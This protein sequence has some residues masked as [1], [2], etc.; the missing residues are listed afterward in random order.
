MAP[1]SGLTSRPSSPGPYVPQ[2]ESLILPDGAL[3][4]E[5]AGLLEDLV[6]HHPHHRRIE[7][8]NEREDDFDADADYHRGREHHKQLPWWKRPSPWWVLCIMPFT[9]IAM[10]ATIAP[11]IEIYTMLACR[12]HKPDIFRQTLP[13]LGGMF[14]FPGTSP[15]LPPMI[16]ANTTFNDNFGI[17]S[18]DM[19]NG[20]STPDKPNNACASDPTVQAAVAK[21]NA[22]ITT[23]MGILSCLT[24]GWWGSFSDRHGRKRLLG[25][26][27]IGVLA[28]DLN[29]IFVSR[30]FQRL[31]GGYWFMILG[32]LIDGSVGSVTAS[33]AAI[34]AYVADTTPEVK[35]SRV[36]SLSLGLLFAGM[37]LGPT[38]GG[39]LIRFSG[40]VLSVF[41]AAAVVHF[42]YA[43]LVWLALPES[44]LKSQMQTSQLKYDKELRK[45][46]LERASNPAVGLLFRSKRLFAFLSPLTTF[47]PEMDPVRPGE[48][49]LKRKRKD[50][51]L[52][53]I[54]AAYGLAFSIMFAASAFGWNS[55][56]MGYWLSMVGA[57]RA[58][59]LAIVLPCIISFFKLRGKTSTLEAS[60]N[61]SE[62]EPFLSDTIQKPKREHSAAFDLGLAHVSLVVEV[63]S[64]TFMAIAP[65]A[66]F[67]TLFSMAAAMGSGLNPALQSVALAMYRRRGGTESGRLFGALSVVQALSSQILGPALYGLVYVKTVATFPRAI[68]IVSMVTIMLSYAFLL[69]VRLPKDS[70]ELNA[71]DA[72]L[73]VGE[74]G[75]LMGE[76]THAPRR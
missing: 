22:V 66:F 69:F 38:L 61:T 57:T 67:F 62:G 24:T 19:K 5:A 23:S 33:V 35:R 47:L 52:T 39:L 6:H 4:E 10:S 30:N 9:A 15:I 18:S 48:N 74:E 56:T 36:F 3:G 76:E 70:S 44:L 13:S 73:A 37:A 41:Y 54:A 14:D 63:I 49:P 32:P 29:F 40:S 58:L 27:V 53:L 45:S 31:P 26:S 50:W 65:T 16:P 42:I 1:R 17:S 60:R 28:T 46:A 68:F 20:G 43:S 12:V 59:F 21:L 72:L 25:I 55:E 7:D 34:H 71:S 2:P 64:Y 75:A 11:R 51:N 8:E